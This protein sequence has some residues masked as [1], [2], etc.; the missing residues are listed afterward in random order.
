METVESICKAC[1]KKFSYAVFVRRKGQVRSLCE[2][3]KEKKTKYGEVL[4]IKEDVKKKKGYEG[5]WKGRTGWYRSKAFVKKDIENLLAG[6]KGRK[7]IILRYNKYHQSADDGRPNFIFAF[8]D[9]READ[10]IVN[11]LPVQSREDEPMTNYDWI[12]SLSPEDLLN[13]LA[14]YRECDCCNWTGLCYIN[15]CWNQKMSWLMSRHK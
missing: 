12:R 13:F 10:A 9:A 2:E 1:G 5:L 4:A 3:C 7:C 15:S 6:E 14:D 8:V 11:E